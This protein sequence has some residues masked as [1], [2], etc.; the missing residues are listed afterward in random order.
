[1][2]LCLRIQCFTFQCK[3]QVTFSCQS[4]QGVIAYLVPTLPHTEREF[5]NNVF[6]CC[7]KAVNC[8]ILK[9]NLKCTY[10]IVFIDEL[11][12]QTVQL[13]IS[14]FMKHEVVIMIKLPLTF[15]PIATSRSVFFSVQ[16]CIYLCFIWTGKITPDTLSHCLLLLFLSYHTR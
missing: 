5:V 3:N 16:H 13:I 2:F 1:M 9:Y 10:F 4:I 12:P 11:L 14:V 8:A 7:R 6:Y 15:I